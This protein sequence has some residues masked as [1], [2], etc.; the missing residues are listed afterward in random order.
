[1]NHLD[2]SKFLKNYQVSRF[3][4]KV[5]HQLR[6]ANEKKNISKTVYMLQKTTYIKSFTLAYKLCV[7]RQSAIAEENKKK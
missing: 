5:N 2:N 3:S 4:K 6:F 7:M 1:M